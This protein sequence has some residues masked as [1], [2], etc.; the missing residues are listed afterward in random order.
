MS[1]KKARSYFPVLSLL[2]L[3]GCFT[4]QQV[5]EVE[6]KSGNYYGKTPIKAVMSPKQLSSNSSYGDNQI[7]IKPLSPIESERSE[8]TQDAKNENYLDAGKVRPKEN[9]YVDQKPKEAPTEKLDAYE[10]QNEQASDTTDLT[11][12]PQQTSLADDTAKTKAS[13]A[14]TFK[15]KTPLNS[16]NFIW[17]ING[18]VLSHYGKNGNKSNEGINISAPAGTIINA[19]ADGKVIYVGKK[20]EGYGNLMIVKHTG[21]YMTAY[22]HLQDVLTEK[23][24]EVKKGESI[25]TVGKTGGVSTPQL[26]FSVR[27]GKKTIDPEGSIG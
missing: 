20:I 13:V 14:S 24:S 1:Y 23:G 8:H 21:D 16:S 22:A 7:S 11:Y 26:H 2:A 4:Q 17:P 10:A 5:A 18:E 27:K 9:K 3:S 19:A 25:A 12:D 6:D 15:T